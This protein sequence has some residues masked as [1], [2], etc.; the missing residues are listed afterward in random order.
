MTI[1]STRP[2]NIF[3][4]GKINSQTVR[5]E[6]PGF[7]KANMIIGDYSEILKLFGAFRLP[8]SFYTKA[9]GAPKAVTI[10]VEIFPPEFVTDNETRKQTLLDIVSL[11]GKDDVDIV[12][13]TT[14]SMIDTPDGG[15]DIRLALYYP[16]FLVVTKNSYLQPSSN[17]IKVSYHT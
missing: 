5:I 7:V 6:E 17:K 4:H 10:N 12:G 9:N 8:Q 1:I 14:A 13:A 11:I 16:E 3:V 15:I 2:T